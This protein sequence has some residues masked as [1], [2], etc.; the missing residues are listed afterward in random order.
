M[1]RTLGGSCSAAGT[2]AP[3]QL[4]VLLAGQVEAQL[5]AAAGP[6]A[7][8]AAA[9]AAWAAAAAGRAAA[10]ACQQLWRRLLQQRLRARSVPAHQK[11]A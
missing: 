6:T 1:P 3:N 5:K 9:A 10:A 2:H 8:A 11:L 4:D 7:V